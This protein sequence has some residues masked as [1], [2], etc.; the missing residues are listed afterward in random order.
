MSGK[1]LIFSAP[2]GSGKTT[3][4]KNLL[5][6]DLNLEFS[7]SATSREKRGNETDGSDYYFFSADQFR[8]KIKR[9]EFVE[10]E[11]VYQDH[12]YGTLLS[13][14]ERIWA[15]G[16]HVIF[17]V[18]VIG[19]LRLKEIYGDRALALFIMPPSV[20]ELKKRLYN[21]ATDTVEIIE[22]RLAKAEEEIQRAESFDR[23]IIN[24]DLDRACKQAYDLIYDFINN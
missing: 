14:V 16:N 1:L 17:D 20:N 11:E 7:I 12:Y 13:E 15:S 10:W 24:D 3:I 23:I 2:S 9:N 4:V 19:G 5:S 6:R 18:D 22:M 8:E 21:R